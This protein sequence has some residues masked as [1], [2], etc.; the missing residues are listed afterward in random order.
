MAT[1]EARILA[2]RANCLHSTGPKTPEGKEISRR[3]GLKHGMAGRG[4]VVREEDAVEVERRDEALR[5]EMDPKSL[6]GSILIRQMATLSVRMERGA[7]QEM[8]AVATLARH[9]AE[10]FDEARVEQA[11]QVFAKI[12]DDP[13]TA[14]RRLRKSPEG[15]DLLLDSWRKLRDRL[16]GPGN[17]SWNGD[18]VK[19]AAQ[20][21]GLKVEEARKGRLGALSMATWGNFEGLAAH[22]GAGEDRK[23]WARARLVE[24][25]GAEILDLEE[26]R[27]TLDLEAIEQDRAEAGDRASFDASNEATLARRYESEARR[28]FFKALKEFR[29]IEAEVE[30]EMDV[31][32]KPAATEPAGTAPPLA[33]C[34]E[35]PQVA[36]EPRPRPALPALP[37]SDRPRGVVKKDRDALGLP[38]RT[39]G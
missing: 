11:E 26:H 29:Q 22:E 10:V 18:Q 21:A 8:A 1:S 16:A 9:A 38:D 28:G 14:V 36:R 15:V 2:N 25:I 20:L 30:D 17:A 3:N 37:A 6:I 34:R 12:A 5:A 35:T 39:G 19:E 4:I 23:A 13:G 33:S 27:A 32:A 31:E 24:W 7:R